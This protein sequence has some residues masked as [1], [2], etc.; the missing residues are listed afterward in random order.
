MTLSELQ[1]AVVALINE[2][3]WFPKAGFEAL[4]D[5]TADIVSEMEK[6][7]AQQGGRGASIL[8]SVGDFDSESSSSKTPV[9][10]QKLACA[11][12]E[13]PSLNRF[14]NQFFSAFQAAEYLAVHLNNQ[15]VGEDTLVCEAIRSAPIPGLINYNVIFG[16]QHTLEAIPTEEE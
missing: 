3:S 11:V 14:N 5:D 7:L 8:V 16:I 6:R 2:E 12:S 1:A 15:Q 4:S 10:S 9:G 13:N